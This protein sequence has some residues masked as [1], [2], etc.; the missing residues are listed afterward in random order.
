MRFKT[1]EEFLKEFG[2][3]W[4]RK[5]LEWTRKMDAL[6]GK[7][8]TPGTET[9]AKLMNVLL[10]HIPCASISTSTSY[11]TVEAWMLTEAEMDYTAK[12][13][14]I[15]KALVN[16]AQQCDYTMEDIAFAALYEIQKGE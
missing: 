5:G 11:W 3:D 4:R 12:I 10:G 8:I 14:R 1:E 15:R 9:Y 13:E 6:F 16:L 7:E 2:P